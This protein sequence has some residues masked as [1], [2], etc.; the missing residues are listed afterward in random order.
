MSFP[1]N[2][3]QTP[4]S[5]PPVQ[6]GYGPPAYG[7]PNPNQ[8]AMGLAIASL[9]LGVIGFTSGCCCLTLP[10]P[11]LAIVLGIIALTQKPDSTAKTLAIAGIVCGGLSL[12]LAFLFFLLGMG[13]AILNNPQ[14]RGGKF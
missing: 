12:L 8:A 11:P 5:F 2:P 7:P 14:F 6:P 13:N 1:N 9:A 4:P 10:L 3:Y